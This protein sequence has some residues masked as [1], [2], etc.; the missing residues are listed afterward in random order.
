MML[1][2]TMVMDK[3][4]CTVVSVVHCCKIEIAVYDEYEV[5]DMKCM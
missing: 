5:V 2:Q 4:W 3:Q 1:L